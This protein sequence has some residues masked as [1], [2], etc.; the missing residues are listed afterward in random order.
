M[1]HTITLV[2]WA[3]TMLV[4]TACS[5]VKK[6]SLTEDAFALIPF[7]DGVENVKE[8]KLSDIA[9]K[10]TLLRLETTD[11]SLVAKPKLNAVSM[12]D[13]RIYIPC[14][15]GLLSF[16]DDG[17]FMGSISR[18]GQGPG[19]Y[20]GLRHVA[21]DET[22]GHIYL[23]DHGKV[24]TFTTDGGFVREN[25]MPFAWQF[26]AMQDSIF[27]SFIYN[28]TGKKEDRLLLTNS[29]ADTLRRFS[30]PDKFEFPGGM[31]WI[32][33]NGKECFLYNHKGDVCFRDYYCDTLYTVSVDSLSPRFVLQ[34][35]K[36]ALPKD[37][38]LE[39]KMMTPESEQALEK[40]KEY[41]RPTIYESDRFLIM[42]YTTWNLMDEE[43]VPQLVVYDKNLQTCVRAK[44]GILKNDMYGTLPFYPLARIA[45]NVLLAYWEAADL[46]EKAET[47]PSLLDSK[48]LKGLKEDDNPVL[49]LVYLKK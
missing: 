48:E 45:E 1:K 9:E 46:L 39:P 19:E 30:Q 13:D 6:E 25:R 47:D 10:V 17:K 18:R 3:L 31:N 2:A 26:S 37:F 42:P 36:Y 11:S 24:M 43:Y 34:M 33:V 16:S 21:T 38:R 29:K 28:N 14:T 40:A 35:G 32:Y 15:I 27:V 44:D 5:S 20:P 4:A 41:L 22:T 8:M 7:V 23:M 12:L 49:M